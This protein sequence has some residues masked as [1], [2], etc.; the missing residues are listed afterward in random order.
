MRK[1]IQ[2]L[3]EINVSE[4]LISWQTCDKNEARDKGVEVIQKTL[5][6]HSEMY[7]YVS[8]LIRRKHYMSFGIDICNV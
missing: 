1:T 5:E 4:M 2:N 6:N 8:K 7:T 3:T